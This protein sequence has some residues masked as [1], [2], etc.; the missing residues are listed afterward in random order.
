METVFDGDFAGSDVGNH[1]GNEEG[2]E[3]GAALCAV[4]G[5]VS[6]LLFEGMNAADSYAEYNA[7]AILINTFE[8]HAAIL[9]SLHGG[10]EGELLVA[11]HL[12]NLLLINKVSGVEVFHLTGKLR[13]ELRGIETLNGCCA[14][15]AR[16]QILPSLF[17]GV[18]NGGEGTEACHY[19][20]F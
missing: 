6:Y 16:H 12:P 2:I 9:H 19:Y 10:D 15:N 11:V 7:D 8:V 20:S 3:A 13:L 1:L 14:A 18:A 4:D 17:K 5:V